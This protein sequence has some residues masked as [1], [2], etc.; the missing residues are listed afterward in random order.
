MQAVERS[1]FEPLQTLGVGLADTLNE[2]VQIYARGK[3][4]KELSRYTTTQSQLDASK[5]QE[6]QAAAAPDKGRDSDGAPLTESQD[7]ITVGGLS[8]K[9]QTL[10][11]AGVGFAAL[12]LGLIAYKAVK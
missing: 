2:S 8:I 4:D 10:K 5:N 1:W 9:N 12:A 7:V 6:A 11:Y 3:L